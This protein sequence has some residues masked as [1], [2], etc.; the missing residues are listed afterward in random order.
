MGMNKV[1]IDVEARF[2][3]HVTGSTK[4]AESA[5]N[6]MGKAADTA[7]KKLDGLGKRPVRSVLDA[8]ASPFLR[9][10]QEA[11]SR[12]KRFANRVYD[13]AVRIKDS[14]ALQTLGKIKGGLE[15]IAKGAWTAT[16]KIKDL[17]TAPLR[18]IRDRLFSVKSL[19]TAIIGGALAKKFVMSPVQQYA[20]YEDLVTQFG[21]L[22]GSQ[23]A[24]E[25]R[26][27]DLVKFAGQTP[28]TRD[29]I[30]QASRVL[31]TY[32]GGAL[33]TPE[34]TGGLKMIG[35]VAAAT[36]Q[37][38]TRVAN[39]FGRL[40]NEVARGGKSLGEPLMM[41]REIG[42]ISAE[43]EEAITKIAQGS[44]TIEQKW[45]HIAQ[46]FS[47][48]D[49]MM[50]AMSNQMNN[51]LL[52]VKSFVRNNLWMRLGKG[53]SESLKP[54]L[55]DFRV[56]RNEN[57]DLIGGWADRIQE[58]AKV[59][60]GKAL[61]AVRNLAKRADEL[62]RSD[63]FQSATIGGKIKLAWDTL[64][65]DPISE[66]WA[67]GGQAKTVAAANTIGGTIGSLLN[68]AILGVLGFASLA[69]EVG[70]DGGSV[71]NAFVQ[72]F[73][74][75]FDGEAIRAAIKDAVS[76]VWD[77][78]KGASLGGKLIT[79][80]I[81]TAVGSKLF[82]P[83]FRGAGSLLRG[84]KGLLGKIFG[85]KTGAGAGTGGL[86]QQVGSMYVNAGVVYVNGAVV[87][88]GGGNPIPAGG[89]LPRGLPAGSAGTPL[90]LPGSAG[91]TGGSLLGKLP[92]LAKV[93]SVISVISAGIKG[94]QWMWRG[95]KSR[96]AGNEN[97]ANTQQAAGMTTWGGIGAGAA[98]GS[99]FPGVGTL[100][101][102][103][104]GGL[105][106]WFTGSKIEKSAES[107]ENST[108]KTHRYIK[109]INQEYRTMGRNFEQSV[110][111]L[112]T[113]KYGK[114]DFRSILDSVKNFLSDGLGD[115]SKGRAFEMD[116]PVD[117][118]PEPRTTVTEDLA[119]RIKQAFAALNPTESET[120]TPEVWIS[121]SYMLTNGSGDPA[122]IVQESVP[123][124]VSAS[125]SVG[126]NTAY[127]VANKLTDSMLARLAGVKS[128][129]SASAT[130]NI[131]LTARVTSN[132]GAAVQAAANAAGAT[133]G[134][135]RAVVGGR[136]YRGGIVGGS[137]AL[138]GFS[139]GGI[140][141]GGPR[142]I[143]VAEEGSPEM[144]IPL[145]S[146]R[147]DRGLKLWEKAGEMLRVPGFARGGR[148]DDGGENPLRVY[149]G[150]EAPG[151]A[152]E[153]H[154]EV[155]GVTVH[156]TV[157]TGAERSVADEVRAQ[158]G[159]ITEAV[160]SAINAALAGVFEN[161]PRKGGAA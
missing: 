130:L 31:Q 32:T 22:L 10:V 68:G 14:A 48:T 9:R 52:G 23:E 79:A 148:T 74:A 24:A 105:V 153:T 160:V 103:G 112:G 122:G 71:A 129:Y 47:S 135:A 2:T 59:A 99:I 44:G 69:T 104:I 150:G 111:F 19:V 149:R 121:P 41:L 136:K 113:P 147:R 4:A 81:V 96:Q 109:G 6:G 98:I 64:V 49:G 102:A 73:L 142:L 65:A 18:S 143:R 78:F 61:D 89:R 63:A 80:G 138:E 124:S 134:A 38:Y 8:D 116:V 21:V 30:F 16:V 126:I 83:L 17:A 155:G 93:A 46:Q 58:F 115:P 7:Q 45:E 132:A 101:G 60:S 50:E 127:R 29:E 125:T 146:Q 114:A 55:A 75:G 43:N 36:G 67:N 5:I 95:H 35:D 159:E 26:M 57:S 120:I 25:K 82:G 110:E 51:L 20:D 39:Y 161:T 131:S 77:T 128:S 13:A 85:G 154:I 3:D 107:V 42:A 119:D 15:M 40:Y 72:G 33:A 100:I 70:A 87:G 76:G 118:K 151:S 90:A 54:F 144:V 139:D 91:R 158:Q 94:G 34:A 84:G 133:F 117:V 56:W 66:W 97:L 53:I 140:V 28:F 156:L 123:D 137:S 92:M 12:A 108:R 106:G 1:V 37:D 86:A 152:G 27:A 88:G 145:S 11:E 62:F 141:R 157:Q